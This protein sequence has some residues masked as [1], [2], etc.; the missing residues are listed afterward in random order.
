MISRILLGHRLIE[1]LVI[2]QN[3][4]ISG[5]E[6]ISIRQSGDQSVRLTPG[7]EEGHILRSHLLRMRL[8]DIGGTDL[9]VLDA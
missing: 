9:Q 7:K 4:C 8:I 6:E 3:H 1:Y 5:E 2:Q